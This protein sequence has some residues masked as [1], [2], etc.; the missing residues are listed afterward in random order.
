MSVVYL[1]PCQTS[2][3]FFLFR[4]QLSTIFA[5]SSILD[6]LQGFKYTS[7]RKVYPPANWKKKTLTFEVSFETKVLHFI[8]IALA[9][10]KASGVKLACS[11]CKIFLL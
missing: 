5:K 4:F 2:M 11:T 6:V 9:I 1:E 3:K 7:V 10:V 8:P